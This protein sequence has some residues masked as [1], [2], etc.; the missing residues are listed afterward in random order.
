[1][2]IHITLMLVV[3]RMLDKLFW[4]CYIDS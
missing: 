3:G 2:I 4:W 1:M